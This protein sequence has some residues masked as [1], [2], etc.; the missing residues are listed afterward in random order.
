MAIAIRFIQSLLSV[1]LLILCCISFIKIKPEG[2][3]DDALTTQLGS[4]QFSFL[5]TLSYT[6][7]LTSGAWAIAVHW[8]KQRPPAPKAA[9]LYDAAFILAYA[10]GGLTAFFSDYVMEC[11]RY[12]STSTKFLNCTS[13]IS[14][15]AM[16]FLI[17]ATF[18][19]SLSIS[20]KAKKS[21]VAYT[22]KGTDGAFA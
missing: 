12:N 22:G 8:Q 6:S 20:L 13:L 4:P 19:V 17:L 2:R 18:G 21:D 1:I 3:A 10:G 15:C 7:W 16:S 5:T 11:K 14:A 9:C